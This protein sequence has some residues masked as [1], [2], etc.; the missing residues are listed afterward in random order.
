MDNYGAAAK[1]RKCKLKA[2]W[3]KLVH[4]CEQD[5]DNLCESIDKTFEQL[6]KIV[7]VQMIVSISEQGQLCS[8]YDFTSVE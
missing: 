1:E 3:Q 6:L 8:V 4:K 2:K 5:T 7:M